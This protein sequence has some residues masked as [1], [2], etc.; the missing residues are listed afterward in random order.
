MSEF[1]DPARPGSPPVDSFKEANTEK[2]NVTQRPRPHQARRQLCFAGSKESCGNSS[3]WR[4]CYN[5]ASNATVRSPLCFV[6][7]QKG[8]T[9]PPFSSAALSVNTKCWKS[10]TRQRLF[11]VL[12]IWHSCPQQ[13]QH[14][15]AEPGLGASPFPAFGSR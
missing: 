3:S 10:R 12:D 8:N 11:G 13:R 2:S 1:F 15:P 5:P 6:R 4:A 9:L 7:H 14:V